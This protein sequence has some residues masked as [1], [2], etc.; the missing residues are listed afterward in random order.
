L[1]GARRVG[2]PFLRGAWADPPSGRLS[3][4]KED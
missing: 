2:V 3:P 1:S 4:L